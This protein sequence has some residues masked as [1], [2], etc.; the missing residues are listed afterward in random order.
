MGTSD[1]VRVEEAIEKVAR[2][3]YEVIEARVCRDSG[4]PPTPWA[5]TSAANR[6]EHRR[7]ARPYVHAA[8]EQSGKE[9]TDG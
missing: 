1:I 5:E 8:L 6:D 2:A 9:G 3:R 7:R 4:L